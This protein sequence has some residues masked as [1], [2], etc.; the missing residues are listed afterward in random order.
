MSPA[1]LLVLILIAALLV[2]GVVANIDLTDSIL[3]ASGI[4]TGEFLIGT[5]LLMFV[6]VIIAYALTYK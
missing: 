1:L 5:F 3:T 6:F 4:D 2:F